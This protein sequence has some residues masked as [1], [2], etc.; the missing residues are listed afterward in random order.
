VNV[1]RQHSV[2]PSLVLIAALG[3]C[4]SAAKHD[5]GVA[6]TAVVN[7]AGQGAGGVGGASGNAAISGSGGSAGAAGSGGTGVSE[8][9]ACCDVH[10]TPGCSDATVQKCVCDQVASC[11]QSAWDLVCVDMVANLGCG[12]CKGDCCKTS[13]GTGCADATIEAC[14]CKGDMGCCTDAWDD[15]CVTLVDGLSCGKC[16]M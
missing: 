9:T 6:G 10:G 15:F 4:S 1:I 11:C 3:A 12:S 5:G 14:V 8:S 13:T 2:L 7:G 16:S